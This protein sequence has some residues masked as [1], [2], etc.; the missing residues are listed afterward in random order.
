MSVGG[1]RE[2]DVALVDDD[3]VE[4]ALRLQVG[5]KGQ[6]I[7]V[8]CRRLGADEH[9]ARRRRGACACLPGRTREAEQA[10]ALHKVRSQRPEREYHDRRA[11]LRDGGG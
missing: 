10:A 6:E 5:G 4:S 3:A 1:R 7:I 8:A 2:E 9:Q 11:C